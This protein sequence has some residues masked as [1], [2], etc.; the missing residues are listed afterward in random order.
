[1]ASTFSDTL[2]H[3]GIL[4]GENNPLRSRTRYDYEIFNI[5]WYSYRG[6]NSKKCFDISCLLC[7]LKN[8]IPKIT[9]FENTTSRHANITKFDSFVHIDVR[10]KSWKFQIHISKI[11]YFTDESVKCR[12]KLEVKNRMAHKMRNRSNYFPKFTWWCHVINI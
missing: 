1:M 5:C 7:K 10:N 4:W 12:K 3:N 2:M 9:I 6:T 11:G 8:K